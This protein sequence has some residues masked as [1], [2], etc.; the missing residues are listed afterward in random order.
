VRK[1]KVVLMTQ[2]NHSNN[3]EDVACSR[4][5]C[6]QIWLCLIVVIYTNFY[7]N[8]VVKSFI[9]VVVGAIASFF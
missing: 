1:E 3:F 2:I 7:G 8:A 9:Q 6:V 4:L 5:Y